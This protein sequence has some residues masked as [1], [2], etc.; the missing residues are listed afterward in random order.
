N[1]AKSRKYDH[2]TRD[3]GISK[4]SYS[5]ASIDQS[6][7]L[8]LE[9]GANVNHLSKGRS[10]GNAL[11]AACMLSGSREIVQLLLD[12]GADV[13]MQIYQ[14]KYGSPLA[15]ACFWERVSSVRLLL[16]AGARLNIEF[17]SECT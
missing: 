16:N 1:P 15:A 3:P 2:I 13:N 7:E 4:Q 12:A 5:G 14:G 6:V 11:I 17:P 8:L 10:Y 9:A